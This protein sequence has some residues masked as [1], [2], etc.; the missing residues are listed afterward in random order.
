MENSIYHL[1]MG[2]AGDPEA[3]VEARGPGV[4]WVALGGTGEIIFLVAA[5][6]GH[7]LP[8]VG[9]TGRIGE[10][11]VFVVVFSVTVLAELGEEAGHIV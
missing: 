9:R 1:F 8:P 11:A 3:D 5:A 7:D 4:L 6:A 2:G 10:G